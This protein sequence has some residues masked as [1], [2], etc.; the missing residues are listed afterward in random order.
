LTGLGDYAAA[1]SLLVHSNQV[2]GQGGAA[3]ALLSQQS[4]ERLEHL[5]SVW[6]KQ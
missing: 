5:Y 4:S 1:E 3:M 6:Q 2:L